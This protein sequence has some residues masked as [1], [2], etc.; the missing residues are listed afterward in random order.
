MGEMG[1]A[2]VMSS[3]VWCVFNEQCVGAMRITTCN[4]TIFCNVNIPGKRA[5]VF[6]G[7]IPVFPVACVSPEN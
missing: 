2:G 5:C 6:Q 3:L 1:G 7:K 4:T